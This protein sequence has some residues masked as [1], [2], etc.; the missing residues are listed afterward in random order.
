MKKVFLFLIIVLI[1]LTIKAQTDPSA[2]N[3]DNIVQPSPTVAAIGKFVDIPVSYYTGTPEISIPIWTVKG[4]TLSVPLSLDYHASGV[5]VEE[6]ASWVGMGWSL[7]GGGVISREKRGRCDEI[8]DYGYFDMQ[9]N[10]ENDFWDWFMNLGVD[11]KSATIDG[12]LYDTEP[13]MFTF[14]FPG[15]QGKFLYDQDNPSGNDFATIPYQ[16]LKI[17][18]EI[19]LDPYGLETNRIIKWIITDE[20]GI[21]YTFDETEETNVNQYSYTSSWHLTRIYDPM[22]DDKI[23]FLYYDV[24]EKFD[25][26]SSVTRY[27]KDPL[28]APTCPDYNHSSAPQKTYM[29]INTKKLKCIQSAITRVDFKINE[30]R[31]DMRENSGCS[32]DTI[33]ITDWLSKKVITSFKFNYQ[34]F[35][36]GT[37]GSLEDFIN[38]RLF[39]DNIYQFNQNNIKDH[40]HFEYDNPDGL[41]PRSSCAQDYWG[42]Y[43]HKNNT[44]LTPSFI[45]NV[46]GAYPYIIEGADR[47]SDFIYAQRGILKKIIYPTGGY[48]EYTYE[49]HEFSYIGNTLASES[50]SS[51]GL[52]E[53]NKSIN[54]QGTILNFEPK[55]FDVDHSQIGKVN[56][57]IPE[58]QCGTQF[59]ITNLNTGR[60]I[61][62]LMENPVYFEIYL[63]S[64]NY[65]IER[66]NSSDTYPEDENK[67]IGIEI[68]YT[69]LAE[70]TDDEKP[71]SKAGGCRVKTINTYDPVKDLFIIKNISYLKY[72]KR[73]KAYRSTGSLTSDVP[74]FYVDY[75]IHYCGDDMENPDNSTFC[76]YLLIS[77][78]SLGQIGTTAGSHI[79]YNEVTV[80]DGEIKYPPKTLISMEDVFKV[81]SIDN[82]KY[83]ENGKTV[84]KYYSNIDYPERDLKTYPAV[85]GGEYNWVK[86]KLK[87]VSQYD[88][89]NR[90]LYKKSYKYNP[91]LQYPTKSKV[92]GRRLKYVRKDLCG[93]TMYSEVDASLYGFSS[94]IYWSDFSYLAE[95]KETQYF[96]NQQDVDSVL[97]TTIYSYYNPIHLQPTSITTTSGFNQTKIQ[98]KYVHDSGISSLKSLFTDKHI[99]TSLYSRDF[100]RNNILIDGFKIDYD[101]N[102]YPSTKSKLYFEKSFNEHL[103]GWG[104][105]SSYYI[106]DEFKYST[107]GNLIQI[108]NKPGSFSSLVW[109]YQYSLPIAKVNDAT[110][111]E[112][113]YENFESAYSPENT[114]WDGYGCGSV[115]PSNSYTIGG[116]SLYPGKKYILSYRK[117]NFGSSDWELVTDTISTTQTEVEYRDININGNFYIDNI[118]FYPMNSL[119]ETY[120]YIPSLGLR[121]VTDTNK[122]S[123]YYEF[124]DFGRLK[125]VKDNDNNTLKEYSYNIQQEPIIAPGNIDFSNISCSSVKLT[126]A[127]NPGVDFYNI[128][129]SESDGAFSLT[130][131]QL[132]A[133]YFI[134]NTLVPNTKYTYKIQ[135]IKGDV[136]SD[137]SNEFILYTP[138]VAPVEITGNNF[139]CDG[140]IETY[141]VTDVDGA[142]NYKWKINNGSIITE[143]E[144]K[145]IE[146]TFGKQQ[147][148]LSVCAVNEFGISG[149]YFSYDIHVG[150]NLTQMISGES[151]IA[152][153]SNCIGGIANYSIN[154]I[155]G[156]VN[157][158]WTV[159]MNWTIIS[160]QG[161]NSISAQTDIF[162]HNENVISVKAEDY[163]GGGYFASKEVIF[164]IVP[165][166]PDNIY[167]LTSVCAGTKNIY[168]VLD[169]GEDP[170]EGVNY[171]W[172][173]P[174][175][176]TINSGQ[177]THTINVTFG[178]ISGNISV[179][180]ENGCGESDYKSKSITVTGAP[181]APGTLA[182]SNS[183]CS[184]STAS[185]S[186]ETVAGATEYIWEVPSGATIVSGQGTTN[187]TITFGNSS[188]NISV[189]AKNDC[190]E[191]TNTTKYITV[192]TAPAIP[193]AINGPAE[194]CSGSSQVYSIS[195][196][197]GA[198][199]YTWAVPTGSTIVSGQGTTSITVNIGSSSGDISVKAVNECFESS[200]KSVAITVITAP[201]I[202]HD[203]VGNTTACSGS[204]ENYRVL[205]ET[206]LVYTW[207]AP[208]GSTIV[209]GQGSSNVNITF[210]STSGNV[211]VKA[212]NGC[213]ESASKTRY[214]N[215][216]S[217]PA[218]P[219][220]ITGSGTCCANETKTYSVA[221]VTGATEY[222]WAVPSG[223]TIVSGQGTTNVTIKL[224]SSSGN[225]SV[226]A[227]NDCFESANKTKYITVKTTPATPSIINGSTEVCSGSSQVYS[228]SAISGASSYTWTVPTGS[229]IVSGQGTTSLTVNMGSTS[230]NISVKAVNEC[231]ESSMK[232]VAITVKTAPQIPSDIIGN[233]AACS[234]STE[235]YRVLGQTGVSYIWTAPTGAT[236]VSGQGSSNVNITL[237]STSGNV[238]VKASN[239][240]F[241]SASKTRYVNVSSIPATPGTIT[242]SSTSCANGTK[243]YSI[244]AVTGATEYNWTVPSGATIVS[245]QGT[246]NVTITFGSS[247]GNV[248]VKAKNDC[249]ESTNKTKYITVK[250]APA[251]PTAI[252]GSAE[253]CSGSSQVYSI[254]AVS[255]A[256]SY[257]WAVPTG[258]T[259][260]SGQGTTSITVN[261]GST[262]GNISVKAVNECFESSLKSVSITVIT[263]PQIPSNIAGNTATCSGSTENY[264]VLGQTGVSYIWTV[265]TGATIASGQGSNNVNVSF[266]STSGNVSVKASNGCFES[267]SKT[268]YVNVSS[269]P[270]TPGT[271][272]GSGTCCANETKTYSVAAVTGATSYL[273]TV[274]SGATI[275]SGLGTRTVSVKFG[276]NSGNIT[277]KASNSCGSSS[278]RTKSVSVTGSVLQFGLGDVITGPS[279]VGISTN[280]TFSVPDIG[281][282]SYNWQI[283]S[284]CTYVSGQGTTSITITTPRLAGTVTIS[285]KPINCIGEGNPISKTFSIS[286]TLR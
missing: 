217:I 78:Q 214:V 54:A 104:Y 192:K 151:I 21:V 66:Y 188:G 274:P 150:S 143:M 84:Y 89:L 91:I 4:K 183:V 262:S 220:T 277:V 31:E 200:T 249:F 166:V 74:Y 133:S 205:G 103:G 240:C 158:I 27:V 237:G 119:M 132:N 32:L 226:K 8:Q 283:P 181:S 195:A 275:V 164:E 61:S 72:N 253:V 128:Y 47:S 12:E 203:I 272:T 280:V 259:I 52:V 42:F 34:V 182:G 113:Y 222:I 98:N 267:A 225:I 230:G 169:P 77:S 189:K 83:G 139:V 25:V 266:G 241:E 229:T 106:S 9:G 227:I 213:F 6:I 116:R 131:S 95:E 264:R 186:I 206:G 148:N 211:S 245:G 35:G 247:S 125:S 23:D 284:G 2:A 159:P 144:G 48:T 233:T 79:D 30:G 161:S 216:S 137:I 265:P 261:I 108:E 162:G 3:I 57:F 7:N 140:D 156:T 165:T 187:V 124:D 81:D 71:F 22:Y 184:G 49:P 157:Y 219:G 244:G 19:A 201:E 97:S 86:G 65:K 149:E 134:D 129:K 255:G 170:A 246:T 20:N 123:T 96:Y 238:S 232:S 204:T 17:E 190:F 1:N 268:S 279:F 102:G 117:R 252:N 28:S 236:I 176:S 5:K 29:S 178:S 62:S 273:W 263:A 105:T 33:V 63:D 207:T 127:L 107:G 13:D 55:Y 228:I 122:K 99:Y 270:A 218:T 50:N 67:E 173:V 64:G 118:E 88:T 94:Y 258:S 248:S 167:G 111:N 278:A 163:C 242:G 90:I 82:Q 251:I 73:E 234:G 269:I 276:S 110:Y 44:T 10:Y 80:Y 194:V 45:Y 177:E 14:S 101:E 58:N 185:Y 285:V 239:G 36:V 60:M 18:Y 223:A 175:G 180:G 121:K 256:T 193:T 153:G 43:N 120:E 38:K 281:A 221:A 155:P 15:H 145:T 168:T 51:I 92:V 26:N 286:R 282:N 115:S 171:N 59:R 39:L 16:N 142:V 136:S 69:S 46:S 130:G 135:S 53:E 76:N 68:L 146:Y 231:F 243:T 37:G 138:P 215:V 87:E 174:E 152:D 202:P 126:W 212:S 100:I 198:S 209:S 24:Q 75:D 112:V 208:T 199:S 141:E 40:F 271:I 114:A 196:V 254:S 93:L 250:T 197:S 191:S 210:G 85:Y 70:Q 109:G 172:I 56:Y 147:I 257:T 41:P 179:R 160:G 11:Q 154:E 260:V 224:G 235:N